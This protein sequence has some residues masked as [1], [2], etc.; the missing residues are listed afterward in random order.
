MGGGGACVVCDNDVGNW[1]L[2]YAQATKTCWDYT[3]EANIFQE[4]YSIMGVA[5]MVQ[6]A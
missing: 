4:W 6:E 1:T 5:K 2:G 3:R